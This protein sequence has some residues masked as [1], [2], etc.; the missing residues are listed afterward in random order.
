[1]VAYAGVVLPASLGPTAAAPSVVAYTLH[2]RLNPSANRL[3]GHGRIGLRNDTAAPIDQVRLSLYYNAP[4]GAAAA[5]EITSL[6][7]ASADRDLLTSSSRASDALRVPI[8]T[9]VPPG[10]EASIDIAWVARVPEAAATG[11][12]VLGTQWFP[13]LASS[14][15]AAAYDV[16]IDV[17]A[18]WAVAATGGEQPAAAPVSGRETHRFTQPRAGDF[19]WAAS[20]DWLEQRAR[21]ERAGLPPVDVRVLVRPEH[22]GQLPRISA[23]AGEAIRQ[24][25]RAFAPYPYADLT[26]V[27]LPWRSVYAGTAYPGLVAIAARWLEPARATDLESDLAAVLARH[28]WQHVVAVDG[29]DRAALPDGLSVYSAQRLDA[30]LVQR[31]LDSPSGDGFLVERFFGGFIPYVNRSIR[32]NHALDHASPDA[33]RTARAMSTLERYLGWPT[34]EV[35]LDDFAARVPFSPTAADFA[36]LASSVS[37]RDLTWFF[38]T[39]FRDQVRF[40]Y[41]VERVIAEAG[42][43]R[44]MHRTTIVVARIGEGIFSGSSRP[45]VDG[46]QSGQAIEVAV[47]FADGSTRHEHW[48]GRDRR[49][50]FVY[51]SIAA[52]D[53][54]EVDPDQRLRLETARTNN[55]W[56]RE[57]RANAAAVLWAA[58]WLIWLENFLLTY[59]TLV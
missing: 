43:T 54:V 44:G 31:Q 39:A 34:V 15:E 23:A 40:D 6:R 2:G 1:M 42:S 55:S 38:A 16:T 8:G 5:L 32:F 24:G 36:A 20:R 22:A 47:T 56:T 29:T 45:R 3:D 12:V 46:Y 11:G 51:D 28:R 14:G 27:D 33:R 48:D 30:A 18:G 19:A 59:T 49:T 13:R 9:P 21:V 25:S 52:V 10:G 50:T 41:A 53:R 17:P 37:G 26:V 4:P 58:P 35:I 7:L 57:P